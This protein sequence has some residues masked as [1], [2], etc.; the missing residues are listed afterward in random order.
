MAS[1]SIVEATKSP[2]PEVPASAFIH[3]VVNNLIFE[4]VEP[5]SVE[6][7]GSFWNKMLYVFSFCFEI[8]HY[9]FLVTK[10]KLTF[11]VTSLL[12]ASAAASPSPRGILKVQE[13]SNIS[14]NSVAKYRING[15]KKEQ[16]WTNTLYLLL[17]E[18]L[19]MPYDNQWFSNLISGHSLTIFEILNDHWI[20]VK[21]GLCIQDF[22][23]L[24]VL[25]VCC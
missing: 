5:T 9:D 16:Q 12:T 23:I 4:A 24:C 6:A 3:E 1:T 18:D 13:M 11:G 25:Y 22:G 21:I 10:F 7:D 19:P 20:H 8:S 15:A 14:R 17:M 2:R